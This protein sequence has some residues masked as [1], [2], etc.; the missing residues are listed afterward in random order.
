MR[1]ATYKK[2]HLVKG[3]SEIDYYLEL[4]QNLAIDPIVQ[5]TVGQIKDT[6]VTA[7]TDRWI[8]SGVQAHCIKYGRNIMLEIEFNFK[9]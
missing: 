9:N 7:D 5:A 6:M 4:D 2:N 1:V 8:L 3:S